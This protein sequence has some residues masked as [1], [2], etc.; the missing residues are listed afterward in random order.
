MIKLIVKNI[1]AGPLRKLTERMGNKLRMSQIWL[2][3][4]E[5]ATDRHCH[6]TSNFR[7]DKFVK[8]FAKVVCI[9]KLVKTFLLTVDCVSHHING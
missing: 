4:L 6:R 7:I 9:A 1:R 2:R 5:L 3:G 8:K